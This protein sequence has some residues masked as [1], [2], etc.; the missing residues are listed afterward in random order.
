MPGILS[1]FRQ[2]LTTVISGN[3]Y[4]LAD[5]TTPLYEDYA[6]GE[7]KKWEIVLRKALRRVLRLPTTGFPNDLLHKLSGVPSIAA[8]LNEKIVE[9]LEMLHKALE[10]NP[11]PEE[12]KLMMRNIEVMSSKQIQRLNLTQDSNKYEIRLK[13]RE[14]QATFWTN[15]DKRLPNFP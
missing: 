11:I 3:L 13:K 12:R 4:G 9:R 7:L 2:A 15:I 8:L 6:R 5:H 1:Q 10:H 14:M